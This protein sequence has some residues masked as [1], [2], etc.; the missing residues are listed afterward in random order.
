M[1]HDHMQ[2]D[3]NLK[4]VDHATQFEVVM[5]SSS[6]C[7]AAIKKFVN[8]IAAEKLPVLSVAVEMMPVCAGS[9]AA[10]N[11]DVSSAAAEKLPVF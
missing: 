4:E 7:Q 1:N 9:V 3:M 5:D 2:V 11:L 6:T 8:S 10:E